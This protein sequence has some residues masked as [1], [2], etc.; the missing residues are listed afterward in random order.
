MVWLMWI[1]MCLL[2]LFVITLL[3]TPKLTVLSSTVTSP[4]CVSQ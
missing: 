3:K 1:L 2:D 4:S